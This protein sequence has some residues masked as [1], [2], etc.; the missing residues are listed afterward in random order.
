MQI[1]RCLLLLNSLLKIARYACIGDFWQVQVLIFEREVL[2]AVCGAEL[3]LHCLIRVPQGAP[4]RHIRLVVD[5]LLYVA[6]M[7]GR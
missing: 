3:R 5:C 4:V 7:P 6:Y 2:H 1:R